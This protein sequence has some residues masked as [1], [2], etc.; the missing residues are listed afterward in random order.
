MTKDNE[1]MIKDNETMIKAIFNIHNTIFNIQLSQQ[2]SISN[3]FAPEVDIDTNYNPQKCWR[4]VQELTSHFWNRW[5]REWLP[6]LSS[7]K[8]GTIHRQIFK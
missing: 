6:S 3:V 5:M 4:R 1:T 8:I 2:Y 7:R